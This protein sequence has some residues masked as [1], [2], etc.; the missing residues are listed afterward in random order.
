MLNVRWTYGSSTKDVLEPIYGY[1]GTKL[2]LADQEEFHRLIKEYR[3]ENGL[4]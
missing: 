1:F 4:D 2:L 3:K